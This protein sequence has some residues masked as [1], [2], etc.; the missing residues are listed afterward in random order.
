MIYRRQAE[1]INEFEQS[2]MLRPDIEQFGY[3]RQF[4]R[5]LNHYRY[6]NGK[7]P[8]WYCWTSSSGIP[9]ISKCAF[10]K[11]NKMNWWPIFSI[12]ARKD[13][14]AMK[15]FCRTTIHTWG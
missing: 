4:L 5:K 9:E 8:V 15:Y 6:D 12:V 14:R 1:S 10:Q 2:A 7:T 3:Y 11:V 13:L